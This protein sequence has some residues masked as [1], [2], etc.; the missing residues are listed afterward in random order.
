M[1][2]ILTKIDINF[3]F[4]INN[5]NLSNLFSGLTPKNQLG[6]KFSNFS[7]IK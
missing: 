6:M 5:F 3:I 7:Q 4:S 1:I 2:K